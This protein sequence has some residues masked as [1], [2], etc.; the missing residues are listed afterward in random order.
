[1]RFSRNQKSTL[2]IFYV[3]TGYCPAAFLL[4]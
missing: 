1:V 4:Q 3:G 2:N